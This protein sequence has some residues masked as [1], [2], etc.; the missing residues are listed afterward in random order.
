MTQ[1]R[2]FCRRND[3]ARI[4]AVVIRVLGDVRHL[5][6]KA[7]AIGLRQMIQPG[8]CGVEAFAFYPIGKQYLVLRQKQVNI[9][10]FPHGPIHIDRLPV[11]QI[12][13]GDQHLIGV[14][15]IPR[16]APLTIIR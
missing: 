3:T 7:R 1:N 16:P 6:K 11:Y 9:L 5:R 8:A 15:Q 10:H 12:T 14:E 13:R 2:S 4:C